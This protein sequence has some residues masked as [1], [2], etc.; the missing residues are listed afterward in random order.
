M[1]DLKL[2][3]GAAVDAAT[4]RGFHR[5]LMLAGVALSAALGVGLTLLVQAIT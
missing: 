5:R 1:K 4:E 3:M 2:K